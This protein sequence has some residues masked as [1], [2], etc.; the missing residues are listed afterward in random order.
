MIA[1]R[2]LLPVALLAVAL[3]VACGGSSPVEDPAPSIASSCEQP[4]TWLDRV[5]SSG[6]RIGTGA[7]GEWTL[8]CPIR[9]LQSAS[10]TV[11]VTHDDTRE[12]QTTLRRPDGTVLSLPALAG[13]NTAGACP[14]G[15]GT[16]WTTSVPVPD[17]QLG[18]YAGPWTVRIVDQL[19]ANNSNGIFYGWSF[20][21]Q[22]LR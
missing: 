9:Q 2:P 22:G 7:Q 15:A 19:P 21:L 13:W 5:R 20:R 3:L 17:P 16:A 11:C 14:P 8:N 6:N 10:L 1:T 12:L 18:D 4:F